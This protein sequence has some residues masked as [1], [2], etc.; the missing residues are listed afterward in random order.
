MKEN[1]ESK[2]GKGQSGRE[3][4]GLRA[5]LSGGDCQVRQQKTKKGRIL[6]PAGR[7]GE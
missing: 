3:G 7:V 6:V 4:M 5:S 1:L 2:E